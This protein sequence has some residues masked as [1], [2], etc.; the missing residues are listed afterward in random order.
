MGIAQSG[1]QKKFAFDTAYPPIS[2]TVL[3][4]DQNFDLY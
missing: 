3:N 4:F 1:T 2:H